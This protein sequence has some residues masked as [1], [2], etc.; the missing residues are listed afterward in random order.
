MTNNSL[1]DYLK[2]T[3]KISN[4]T[5]FVAIEEGTLLLPRFIFV[6]VLR[7]VIM[8]SNYIILIKN[9]HKQ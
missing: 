6:F 1:S 4:D 7:R 2:K 9:G 5:I 8:F 3:G